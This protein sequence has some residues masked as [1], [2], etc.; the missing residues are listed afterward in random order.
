MALTFHLFLI[1]EQTL[2][3]TQRE[4]NQEELGEGIGDE[5]ECGN[6]RQ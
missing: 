1:T 5:G 2:G 3:T 4:K 6:P